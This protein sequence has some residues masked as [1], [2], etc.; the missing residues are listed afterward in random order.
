MNPELQLQIN[1]HI[2][3]TVES[4]HASYRDLIANMGREVSEARLTISFQEEQIANLKAEKE[5]LKEEL[6]LMAKEQENKDSEVPNG[7]TIDHKGKVVAR[8]K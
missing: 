4:V 8:S 7:S 1:Q 3:K 2:S 6:E 5:K